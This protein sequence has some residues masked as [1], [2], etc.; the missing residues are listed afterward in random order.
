[1]SLAHLMQVL[2]HSKL[3]FGLSEEVQ[4][5][6]KPLGLKRFEFLKITDPHNLFAIH[7]SSYRLLHTATTMG[8]RAKHRTVADKAL[9]AKTYNHLYNQSL[10]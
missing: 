6:G 3:I 7:L 5:I 8:R 4:S 2:D 10:M 9:A 1:M